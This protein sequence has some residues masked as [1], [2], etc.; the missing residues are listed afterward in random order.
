LSITT[1]LDVASGTWTVPDLSSIRWLPT[2][3][4]LAAAVAL[5][6][7]K[8]PMIPVLLASASVGVAATLLVLSLA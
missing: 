8:A 6:R 2:G 1:P 3:L 5:V 7:L 4:F